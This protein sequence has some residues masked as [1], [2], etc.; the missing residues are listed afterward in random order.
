MLYIIKINNKYFYSF[1]S[2]TEK[3]EKYST[4]K[5]KQID[6]SL[7]IF[8]ISSNENISLE[9]V[10]E[11]IKKILQYV[12][13]AK[14]DMFEKKYEEASSA[15]ECAA[16]LCFKLGDSKRARNYYAYAAITKEKSEKWR[17]ISYLWYRASGAMSQI[18]EY[19]DFNSLQ[20][21]YPTTS[22]EKWNSLE[23]KEKKARAIQYAAYS[24]D[25]YGGP[26]DSYWLYEEAANA[27]KEAKNYGRMIECLVSA[28][29][30][31]I[32]QYNTISPKIM[33]D[34]KEILKDKDIVSKFRKM[35]ILTFEELYKNINRYDS[36]NAKFF[37]IESK[38]LNISECWI[39]KKYLKSI[40]NVIWMFYS[41]FNTSCLK[42]IV[43]S[44]II[45]LLV[46]PGLFVLINPEQHFLD[47]IILSINNFLGIE[48]IPDG[49]LLLFITCVVEVIY[50]YFILVI[51]STYLIGK[52]IK[53]LK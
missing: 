43:Q 14:E 39:Q 17:S 38:K 10:M 22:M 8:T 24:E 20:H 21:T 1:D 6:N 34:W 49:N 50:A 15:F 51:I 27:Y 33:D 32:K 30:R 18:K 16:D 19:K 48:T 40:C 44:I 41:N 5:I 7:E 37:Y 28:T 4:D 45:V 47:A 36:E 23:Q 53:E 3:Y 42:I 9:I 2:E 12:Y 11:S 31:Y 46:F 25:N 52:A 13:S 35:I 26:T 29:N